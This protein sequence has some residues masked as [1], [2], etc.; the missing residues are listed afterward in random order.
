[1]AIGINEFAPSYDTYEYGST[2]GPSPI[3]VEVPKAKKSSKKK[4]STYKVSKPAQNVFGGLSP[5][6]GAV[7]VSSDG[8]A[9]WQEQ[10]R[11]FAPGYDT[12]RGLGLMDAILSSYPGITPEDAAAVAGNFMQESYAIPNIYQGENPSNAGTTKRKDGGYGL[13]QW[14]GPRR[15]ALMAMPSP[16]TLDTQMQYFMQEN[17]GPEAT[18]W[19]EVLAA[20][21]LNAKTETFMREWER[22]GV[23]ALQNRLN[24]AN[25]IY[26]LYSNRQRMLDRLMAPI[27]RV[28]TAPIEIVRPNLDANLML[29]QP[30]LV[31]P[32]NV[33]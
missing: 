24:F 20:P 21:N 6:Q 3:T 7:A 8:G 29:R 16:E 26:N 9:T 31:V 1:M 11:G 19:Q 23:P 17:A 15:Q 28:P 22:P 13:A 12:E 18:N 14:T 2:P 32:A 33:E 25:D 5:E 27:T 10:P 4:S 30:R